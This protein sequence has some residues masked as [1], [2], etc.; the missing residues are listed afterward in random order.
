MQIH[1]NDDYAD[2]VDG[3]KGR[4][5]L[6]TYSRNIYFNL[7]CISFG[8]LSSYSD[9]AQLNSKV[10]TNKETGSVFDTIG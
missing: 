7:S 1:S 10:G 6:I 5:A 8:K 3:I 9:L 4:I 2:D